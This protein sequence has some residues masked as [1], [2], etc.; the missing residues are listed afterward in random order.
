MVDVGWY[1]CLLLLS[2]SNY[3]GS[4]DY[5]IQRQHGH[6]YFLHHSKL[7]CLNY[8]FLAI[9]MQ[10]L[11][12]V[13]L[14]MN[15][16][17]KFYSLYMT[18]K[19]FMN[20]NDILV[21]PIWYNDKILIGDSPIFLKNLFDKKVRFVCDLFDK[22][23]HFYRYNTLCTIYD[24]HIPITIYLGLKNSILNKWP[25]LKTLN[26]NIPFPHIPTSIKLFTKNKASKDLYNTFLVNISHNQ[27]Y[28]NKWLNELNLPNNCSD[29]LLRS[30]SNIFQ[31]T[32]DSTL[33]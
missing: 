11:F 21:S 22:N 16:G 10:N 27:N 29:H 8:N 20:N 28:I 30:M 17:M 2:H 19:I 1:M 9:P 5:L 31:C 33:R 14:K 13:N 4:K 18:L 32:S 15:F 24:I 7:T 25:Q 6:T 3:L 12:Q 26:N 23:G